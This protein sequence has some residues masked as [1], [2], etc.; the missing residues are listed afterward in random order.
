MKIK[1]KILGVLGLVLPFAGAAQPKENNFDKLF[2]GV[3]NVFKANHYSQRSYND[4]FALKLFTQYLGWLDKDQLIFQQPDIAAL[5]QAGLQIDD[6]LNGAPAQFQLQAAAIYRK[7]VLESEAICNAIL[8]KPFRFSKEETWQ[9]PMPGS[10]NFP[11]NK[12]EQIEKLNRW[13]KWQALERLAKMPVKEMG[14]AD[15]EQVVRK[16]LRDNMQKKFA[17]CTHYPDSLFAGQYLKMI[18]F[19]ADP[20]S[21]Y[22]TAEEM[23]AWRSAMGGEKA[24]YYGVGLPL[25]EEDGYVKVISTIAGG[26]AAAS[27]QIGAG[28]ILLAVEQNGK[29]EPVAGHTISEIVYLVLGQEGTKV[30]LHIR[31][32]DG[33]SRAVTLQRAE[34][35]QDPQWASSLLI[36]KEG[37][38]IGYLK[39]PMFYSGERSCFM[40]IRKEVKK[41]K[42]ENVEGIIIDLRNNEGGSFM[43]VSQMIGDFIPMGPR[44]QIKDKEG[45]IDSNL[46][47][48]GKTIYDGP[49][50]VMVNSGS[51]SASELFSSA[52]QDY[53]RALIVGSPSFGKGT[54]QTSQAIV[55][56]VPNFNG[57][58]LYTDPLGGEFW[59]TV[60]KFYRISG[61]SVQLKGVT[62]DVLLPDYLDYTN[63]RRERN[64]LNALPYDEIKPADYTTWNVGYNLAEIKSKLQARVNEMPEF[65]QLQQNQEQLQNIYKTPAS[66]SWNKYME[67]QQTANTLLEACRK[68]QK[69]T[70]TQKLSLSAT[71]TNKNVVNIKQLAS[72]NLLKEN[73]ETDRE[74]DVAAD[75]IILMANENQNGKK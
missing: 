22:N 21:F 57:G 65:K 70:V 71:N 27:G 6:E 13:L 30:T 64:K 35:P 10:L 54:V 75:A 17:E 7:R 31:K 25:K 20:H 60:Q 29:K 39:L 33:S 69:L 24:A 52:M 50:V 67:G 28:D 3:A 38:K 34:L 45:K 44:V 51:A 11:A 47:T 12:T 9:N 41:L 72:Q 59:M 74:V 40:D 16:I 42:A 55:E 23:K 37:K 26:A 4:S 14:K 43:D 66:L 49:L 53:K 61:A 68:L 62:P 1:V 19:S 73:V 32:P 8:N 18:P 15:A 2:H 5:Q 36:E 48:D 58:F 46:D 56:K 63:D